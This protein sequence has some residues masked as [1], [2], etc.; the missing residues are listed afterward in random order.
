MIQRIQ[1][2]WLLLAV[3]AG[4]LSIKFPFYT[5]HTLDYNALIE[6]RGSWNVPILIITVISAL[7]S[8]IAIFLYKNRRK[9]TT[10][11]IINIILSLIII[12][13]YFLQTRNFIEGSFSLTSLFVFSIPIFLILALA[14]VRRDARIIRSLDRLR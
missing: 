12:I 10:Y 11:I 8:G 14:G 9:Q 1:T 4:I 7:I 3:I 5:G 2:L 6:L 13:L